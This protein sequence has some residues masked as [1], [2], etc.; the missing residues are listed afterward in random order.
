MLVLI[1]GGNGQLAGDFKRLFEE[2]GIEYLAPSHREMDIEN[3]ENIEKYIENKK[4][5]VIINCAAYNQVDRGQIEREKA[6]GTNTYGVKNLAEVA[7]KIDAIYMTYSTDFVFGGEKNTP[8]MEEDKTQPLSIYG[9]SKLLGEKYV[10]EIWEKSF[11]I[12]T[13]WV[14]GIGNNNFVKQII[15]WSKDKKELSIVDDQISSPTYSYDLARYS[16]KLFET[17]KYG[18][19][20]LCNS[21]VCSRYEEA[22]YILEKIGWNGELKR[23]KC[24]DFDPIGIRPNYSKISCKKSENLIGKMPDWKSGVDRFLEEMESKNEI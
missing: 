9:E 23:A 17:R 16:W 14:F 5:D 1:S 2:I 20:H 24:K 11:I 15:N 8:Y 12:R 13:S 7:K 3:I 4:I 10:Q 6:F 21:G 19:Y 18:I 22:K